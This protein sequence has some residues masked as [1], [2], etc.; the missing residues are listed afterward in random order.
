[1]HEKGI[2]LLS[3][4]PQ[5]KPSDSSIGKRVA[6]LSDARRTLLP[7]FP[8]TKLCYALSEA[9]MAFMIFMRACGR[10]RKYRTRCYVRTMYTHTARWHPYLS[11]PN[12]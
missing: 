10:Q 9:A 1:M 2:Q 6:A 12:T 7:P 5:Q 3:C 8:T 11:D 4:E